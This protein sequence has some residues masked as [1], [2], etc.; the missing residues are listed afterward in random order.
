MHKETV[1]KIVAN[2]SARGMSGTGNG[3]GVNHARDVQFGGEISV[4][5]DEGTGGRGDVIVREAMGGSEKGGEK[6]F[7]A[8]GNATVLSGGESGVMVGEEAG[9]AVEDGAEIAATLEEDVGGAV[10]V[11][12]RS[13]DDGGV[14]GTDRK[15]KGV[16]KPGPAKRKNGRPSLFKERCTKSDL[17]EKLVLL[18]YLAA[19][20]K[21]PGDP[22]LKQYH[23]IVWRRCTQM[24]MAEFGSD[25]LSTGLLLGG[26]TLVHE[27][28]EPLPKREQ[29]QKVLAKLSLVQ[30]EKTL[31][32]AQC[33]LEALMGEGDL[34]MYDMLMG[35]IFAEGSGRV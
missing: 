6:L 20:L 16:A 33:A 29:W 25:Q 15:G 31:R 5:G 12:A 35:N 17:M 34:E 14:T 19:Q 11:T 28:T 27:E 10:E 24:G 9:S 1:V 23:E 4:Q 21:V 2:N 30:D 13:E 32:Y 7:G 8:L 18:E 26:S 3:D 22:Y